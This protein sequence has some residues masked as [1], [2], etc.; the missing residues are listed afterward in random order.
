MDLCHQNGGSD[1]SK[2]CEKKGIGSLA[3]TFFVHTNYNC[4]R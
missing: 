1:N 4:A 2:K 3:Y